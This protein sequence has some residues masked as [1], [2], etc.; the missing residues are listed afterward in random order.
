ML[1]AFVAI[2]SGSQQLLVI[3]NEK[4]QRPG[5]NHNKLPAPDLKD[6]DKKESERLYQ[7]AIIER[8]RDKEE[9]DRP[10]TSLVFAL[11]APMML[12]SL[13]VVAFLAGLSSVIFAPLATKPVWDDNAKL[14][15]MP[16][17]IHLLTDIDCGRVQ[18]IGRLMRRHFRRFLVPDTR[19][20]QP[21]A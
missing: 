2:I 3:P 21:G 19:T 4:L 1:L 7:Q 11:Q 6:R 12:L 15:R 9:K 8:L 14:C 10:N 17:I 16:W 5:D 13:S 18:R 20:F